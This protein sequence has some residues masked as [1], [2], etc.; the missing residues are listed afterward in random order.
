MID[1]GAERAWAALSDAQRDR[2]DH[3]RRAFEADWL[4]GICPPIEAF[5][6]AADEAERPALVRVLLS[7]E[8]ELRRARGERPVMAD[9]IQRFPEHAAAVATLLKYPLTRASDT[10]TTRSAPT[11]GPSAAAVAS[12]AWLAR[13]QIEK[14][15]GAGGFGHVYQAH[16]HEL[17]R[18]L[19][20]KVLLERH[21]ENRELVERFVDEA[22]I[23]GQLQHPGLVPV[24]KLGTLGDAQP[25]FTMKLVQGDT[26]ATLLARRASPES[27][28][29]RFLSIFETVCQTV[30]YAHTR[31]VIHRDLKP[32]NIMIG[33]FGEVMVMDWGLAKVLSGHDVG[34]AVDAAETGEL[35]AER[36]RA[37]TVMGTPA[38]MAPEQA[39]GEVD[40]LDERADVFALGSILCE[41]LTGQPAYAGPTPLDILG[42]AARGELAAARGRIELSGADRELI[43]LALALLAPAIA[44][45]PRDAGVVAG[46]ITAYR[47]AIDEKLRAAKLARAAETA[48]VI[49]AQQ[50]AV[51]ARA[52]AAAERRARRMTVAATVAA[53]GVF[54]A[55][56][57][58]YQWIEFQR[59]QQRLAT[60]QAVFR[61][62]AEASR[63]E[64]SALAAPVGDLTLWAE[65]V[66]AAQRAHDI[67]K[68]GEPEPALGGRV[69]ALLS[70]IARERDA[71]AAQ[72]E[73]VRA[74]QTLIAR[75]ERLRG[76]RA[77]HMDH[78]RANADYTA[79]F[80]EAG[81]DLARMKQAAVTTWFASRAQPA[82]L[83][84][85][86][87]DWAA[88][89]R[90]VD[91]RAPAWGRLVAAAR[92]AD[93]DPWRD[94]LRTQL[95]ERQAVAVEA[96]GRIAD[97]R[98][99]L[100]T[101]PAVSLVLLARQLKSVV[102]DAERAAR[103]L[104][105]A[106]RRDPGDFW[107]H[108]E[109]GLIRARGTRT[110]EEYFPRPDEAVEQLTTA[111]ALRPHSPL[112]YHFL[113]F[114]L[115]AQARLAEAVTAYRKAIW[116]KP[117]LMMSQY[118]VG[119][120]LL[121]LGRTAEAIVPLREA[122]RL[123]PNAGEPH[124]N[125]AAALAR[126]G[127]FAE[128][129]AE[130]RRGDEL[131]K[132]RPG[133]SYP[134]AEWVSQAERASALAERL[135]AVLSGKER[136][137]AASDRVEFAHVAHALKSYR[138]AARL[139]AEAL[140]EQNNLLDDGALR[141][142]AACA[143]AQAGC[144]RGVGEPRADA[145]ERAVLRCQARDWLRAGITAWRRAIDSGV[146]G[147]RRAAV[148]DLQQAQADPDLAGVRDP[149]ALALLPEAEQIEWRK[150]WMEVD[151]LLDRA[152]ANRAQPTSTVP[153]R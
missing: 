88:E 38:Y 8:L 79:A 129:L 100:D 51:A 18:D 5:L 113:A 37:G 81:L 94:R 14:T 15:L 119:T 2:I 35:A 58:G 48:R 39:R 97:D 128:S 98:S 71:A 43:N 77:E 70:R 32:A 124:C 64:G 141:W 140:R 152:R 26:L 121:Q 92:V 105:I 45:R 34:T 9:Y 131:G 151:A 41:I 52:R 95:L 93:P 31:G 122:I 142:E 10:H 65:A 143:T 138:A 111:V 53:V 109:L 75:L 120:V 73:R 127:Q 55:A 80:R 66:A 115:Q 44:D 117:D 104:A 16:D 6:S 110:A 82:A 89:L 27:E 72:A 12:P 106:A 28:P 84:A 144:E 123:D 76:D 74:D 17:G 132:R 86:L 47:A 114:A 20:I 153:Q 19:A 61:A 23:A 22:R 49:G 63:L 60:A 24:Y 139:Y 21:R 102:G 101:Q 59:A 54:V 83:A 125:L 96:L 116:L 148:V 118:N 36:S 78:T 13:Y 29:T 137:T 91:E 42:Q 7:S 149:A 112:A 67:V 133:W 134:S 11:D 99:V 33:G 87:D 136:I 69:T 30:A 4:D 145:D 62:I 130:Y 135:P 50:T 68:Q 103:V 126:Q 57:G 150:L 147:S 56:G 1:S 85:Y 107:I 40:R 25:F 46:R 3:A 108:F 90:R 146:A